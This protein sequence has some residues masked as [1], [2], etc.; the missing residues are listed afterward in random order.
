MNASHHSHHPMA[1]AEDSG[2]N[3]RH[4][5]GHNSERGVVVLAVAMFMVIFVATAALVV[6][7]G[8]AKQVRRHAQN[9]ADAAALA[10]AQEL[11]G[12][13]AALTQAVTTAKAWAHKNDPELTA[14][15]WVGCK[16]SDALSVTPDLS[17]ECISFSSDRL[18]VRVALP[19]RRQPVAFGAVV[20]SEGIVI[21]ASAHATKQMSNPSNAVAGPCGL[22]SIGS[23]LQIGGDATIEVTN[24]EIQANSLTANSNDSHRGISP[25][26]LRWYY[27]NWSNWG[28]NAQPAP[29][30]FDSFYSPLSA[31]VPN[32]FADK[33]VSY[34]GLVID[35]SNISHNN[36]VTNNLI[37]PN[38]IYTQGININ[39]GTVNLAPGH[40]YIRGQLRVQN[41]ATLNGHGVTLVFVCES[42][43]GNG[44]GHF[45]FGQNSTVNITAPTSGPYTGMAIMFDPDGQNGTASQMR[46]K[47]TLEGAVY[48][49]NAGIHISDSN[50]VIRSWTMVS[51]GIL[52]INGSPKVYI[53]NQAY[54][55]SGGSS[56]GGSGVPGGV[57][58]TG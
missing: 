47:V 32:P 28:R 7:I 11:D 34:A 44:I 48:N 54:Y 22:C 51:G 53:D 21:S 39:G 17:N 13:S 3:S 43:C 25:A 8:Y 24:G 12:T 4:N 5:S 19:P 57:G 42:K 26:P 1:G 31:P 6:D 15:S 55:D 35:R 14:G 38:R 9:T 49:K 2:H 27:N 40:Y 58:L 52:D 10:A 23:H 45:E 50:S 20:G 37:Q 56:G 30:T 16:D 33:D 46:G 29:A 41:N 36:G 18:T